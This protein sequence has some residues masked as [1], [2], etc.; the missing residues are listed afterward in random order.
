MNVGEAGNGVGRG[1]FS[2]ISQ[3]T[4]QQQQQQKKKADDDEARKK[5]VSFF[6]LFAFAD[7]YDYVLMAIGSLGACVHGVSVPVFFIFF[8]KLINIIGVAYLFPASVSHKVAKYA[9]DFVYLGIAI[10]FSS[11]TE[12]ACWMHTGE[13]QAAKMRLAYLQSML[14]QDIG[15]FDTEATTGEVIAA[16]TSDVL[17]VQDAIS[18]K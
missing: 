4:K 17:I 7:F 6:K 9:L 2:G 16:I 18:E 15:H 3:A 10:M 5:K 1:S 13:R 8:G 14:N 11:W 12:V